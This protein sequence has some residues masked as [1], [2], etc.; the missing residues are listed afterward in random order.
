MT[1]QSLTDRES[2]SQL[3]RFQVAGFLTMSALA[4]LLSLTL[5]SPI[6]F[7]AGMA[8]AVV[9]VALLGIP[10]GALD[11]MHLRY[12]ATRLGR[13]EILWIGLAVYVLLGCLVIVAWV[14]FP[15]AMLTAFLIA[16]VLHWGSEDAQAP[17]AWDLGYV[18]EVLL[19]GAIP[20]ML[21]SVFYAAETTW[22]FSQ[23]IPPD[24]ARALT[25][26]IGVAWPALLVLA[27]PLLAR[28]PIRAG[29][30]PHGQGT[31]L[32][33]LA[34]VAALFAVTPPLVAF[35]VYFGLLHSARFLARYA[36]DRHPARR[37][38]AIKRSV[39]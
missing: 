10:H 36:A 34:T 25:Q 28:P 3:G 15:A 11:L 5:Q 37:G 19:R 35:A 38:G 9:S 18:S 12:L 13:A 21:P 8:V 17:R 4:I 27:I 31:T 16:T 7:A 20:I 30:R 6:P 33:E 2:A 26:V 29:S 1:T 23:L 14:A 32:I 39:E 22:L 24:D